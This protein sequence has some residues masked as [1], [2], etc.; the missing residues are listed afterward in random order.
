MKLAY[1]TS[2]KNVPQALSSSTVSL[3]TLSKNITLI[4][5]ISNLL[6]TEQHANFNVFYKLILN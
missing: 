3:C 5:T 2:I 4:S 6:F 1:C